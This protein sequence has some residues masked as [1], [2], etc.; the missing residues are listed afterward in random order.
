MSTARPRRF[1]RVA[2]RVR[3]RRAPSARLD[4]SKSL[5]RQAFSGRDVLSELPY[6]PLLMGEVMSTP[7]GRT[8]SRKVAAHASR[9]RLNP[10]VHHA[11]QAD[12]LM[13]LRLLSVRRPATRAPNQAMNGTSSSNAVS[14]RWTV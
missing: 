2:R 12:A 6:E 9:G 11:R 1:R 8:V 5:G 7:Q 10:P 14:T 4:L 13:T 3:R